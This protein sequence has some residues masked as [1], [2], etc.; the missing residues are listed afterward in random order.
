[1]FLDAAVKAG[2]VTISFQRLGVFQKF[3]FK[4]GKLIGGDLSVEQQMNVVLEVSLGH[5]D[6]SD[7]VFS[8]QIFSASRMRCKLVRRLPEVRSSSFACCSSD[9]PWV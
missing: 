4:R 1:M 8:T 9:L 6:C 2:V 3:G 7:R 5:F